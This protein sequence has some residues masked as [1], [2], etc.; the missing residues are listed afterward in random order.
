[1]EKYDI[2]RYYVMA[3]GWFVF[4]ILDVVFRFRSV[5]RDM[6]KYLTIDTVLSGYYQIV[7]FSYAPLLGVQGLWAGNSIFLPEWS[8][9][10]AE[11]DADGLVQGLVIVFLVIPITVLVW[12]VYEPDWSI[13]LRTVTI[14]GWFYSNRA[15]Y[16]NSRI[17]MGPKKECES[18]FADDDAK[19][20]QVSASSI[21]SKSS[22]SKK[23]N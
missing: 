14:P 16:S 15:W 1:M 17:R 6:I 4:I 5:I 13:R 21:G 2:H 18:I 10:Y 23:E 20:G 8:Y 7:R 3:I 11:F 12:Y 9:F 19:K 22:I